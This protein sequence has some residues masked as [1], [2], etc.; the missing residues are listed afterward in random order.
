MSAQDEGFAHSLT[1]L[2]ASVAAM[3]LLI[4]AIFIVRSLAEQ[5][6]A[7]VEAEQSRAR[8]QEAK[9]EDLS[10]RETLSE[11]AR[12][13]TEDESIKARVNYDPS[14]DP[15]LMTIVFDEQILHFET[16]HDRP[17]EE[18]IRTLR[19]VGPTILSAVC[20]VA[21]QGRVQQIT[22]EGHTDSQ[23]FRPAACMGADRATCGFEQNVELS[24][25]R[26]QAVYFHL[27]RAIDRRQEDE[28]MRCLDEHFVVAGRGPVEPYD[29]GDWQGSQDKEARARN[30]RVVIKVRM[31][32]DIKSLGVASLPE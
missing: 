10:S 21:E 31:R 22:L 3:F 18:G 30:R 15:F 16:G 19:E 17:N 26:A 12:R 6:R 9:N 11:L 29:G 13:L 7:E 20:N 23:P 5:R 8:L 28:L 2:M 27:R 4:A 1:D 24:A 25:R 14:V 32:S